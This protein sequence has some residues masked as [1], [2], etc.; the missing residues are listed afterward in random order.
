MIP[1]IE[2]GEKGCQDIRIMPEIILGGR[3]LGNWGVAGRMG[4]EN[5]MLAGKW[6]DKK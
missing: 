4:N 6:I 5:M 2:E 3:R 1:N